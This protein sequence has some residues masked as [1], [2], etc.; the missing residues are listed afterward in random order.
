MICYRIV[1]SIY[2]N[3]ISG[4]GAEKYG[5][6]WNSIGTPALYCCE[7]RSLAL[8]EILVNL[9]PS[10]V[11]QG[12][13]ILTIEFPDSYKIYEP[14]LKDLPKDWDVVPLSNT[15]QLFGDVFI[16]ENKFL[17]MKVPSSIMR[18]EY[19]FVLNP[20][21]TGFEKVKIKEHTS[22]TIDTRL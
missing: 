17:A 22:Y 13:T 18:F 15:S 3:D 14:S 12:Y 5:G 16:E 7:N 8:L 2:K 6:R 11:V 21:H 10:T 4:E 1:R 9:H 20:K 19:N